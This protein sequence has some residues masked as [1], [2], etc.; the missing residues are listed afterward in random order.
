LTRTTRRL[1]LLHANDPKQLPTNLQPF[2]DPGNGL[3]TRTRMTTT[4]NSLTRTTRTTAARDSESR[5]ASGT[6]LP[7]LFFV[8]SSTTPTPHLEVFFFFFLIIFFLLFIP[9]TQ[10]PSPTTP[11]LAAYGGHPS[12]RGVFFYFFIFLFTSFYTYDA[13]PVTYNAQS[14]CLR[15]PP[16]ISRGFLFYFYF[17]YITSFYTYDAATSARHLQCPIRLPKPTT[18]PTPKVGLMHNLQTSRGLA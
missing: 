13:A 10:R 2:Q 4:K 12:S 8:I 15:R 11:N 6:C 1:P 3:E 5:K 7:P 16:L 17:L 18:L 14:G 9:T